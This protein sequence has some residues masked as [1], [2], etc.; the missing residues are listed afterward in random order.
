MFFVGYR[1]QNTVRCLL[2]LKYIL[3]V[4][5]NVLNMFFKHKT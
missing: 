5:Y 1:V 2:K 3:K 4:K